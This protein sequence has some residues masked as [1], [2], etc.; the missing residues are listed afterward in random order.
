MGCSEIEEIWTPNIKVGHDFVPYTVRLERR[1]VCCGRE[2][3]NLFINGKEVYDHGLSDHCYWWSPLSTSGGRYEWQ[4]H[5]HTFLLVYNVLSCACAK[6]HRLFVDGFDVITG[7]EFS[8]YWRCRGW[9]FLLCGAFLL[10]LGAGGT[11]LVVMVGLGQL[12]VPL[13]CY[14]W[15]VIFFTIG[16][17]AVVKF[18]KSGDIQHLMLTERTPISHYSPAN[19]AIV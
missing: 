11:V 15:G 18:R 8:D 3:K 16:L 13:N 5:G 14:S 19:A 12:A 9:L 17:V 1:F 7:H 10:L 4:E 6:D 2:V